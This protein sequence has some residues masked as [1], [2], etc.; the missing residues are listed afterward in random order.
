MGGFRTNMKYVKVLFSNGEKFR[1]PATTI[2]YD[3]ARYY[4]H[5]D[6]PNSTVTDPEWT[7]TYNDE[8][9]YTLDDDSE[10]LDWL[11]NNMN[12]EDVQQDAERVVTTDD[13]YVYEEHWNE[14]SENDSN[15]EIVDE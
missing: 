11:W 1:I 3:R 5:R 8:K 13:Q 7:K 12:W 2:A 14:I 15:V 9:K 6:N 4:A 10:L